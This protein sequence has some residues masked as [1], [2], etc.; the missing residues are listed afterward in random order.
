MQFR[1]LKL[2]IKEG[3]HVSAACL[4]GSPIHKE[5]VKSDIPVEVFKP[6]IKNIGNLFKF[7]NILNKK[8]YNLIHTHFS[9]DL[10]LVIPALK[11]INSN[12]PVILTK[13]LGSA[14]SKK[15]FFHNIIYN[16]LD[17]AIAISERNQEK[18]S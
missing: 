9:K 8:K 3:Y 14:I 11:L 13:H 4:A 1:S 18:P 15:D 5:L 7:I 16:R 2:L 6:S 10:W 12:I 17:Y